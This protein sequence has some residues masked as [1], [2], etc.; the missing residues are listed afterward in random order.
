MI[1]TPEWPAPANVHAALTT[2]LGG[3]SKP[4][5]DSMNLG[6]HVGDNP[7]NVDRNRQLVR[8]SLASAPS[9]IQWLNQVHGTHIAHLIAQPDQH[10]APLEADAAITRQPQLAC[11]V[12]TADCLP[13]LICDQ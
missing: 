4:P 8:Q 1:L 12:M 11:C 7:V 9:Q 13:V 2:R 6:F 10:Y 3:C 5:F